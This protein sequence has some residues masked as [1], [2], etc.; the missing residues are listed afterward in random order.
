MQRY[1]PLITFAKMKGLPNLSF[2]FILHS[3][4]YKKWIVTVCKLCNNMHIID[5][6]NLV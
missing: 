6:N 2:S 1:V 3:T 5:A 4:R